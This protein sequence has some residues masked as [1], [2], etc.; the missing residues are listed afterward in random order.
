MYLYLKWKFVNKI[1]W[2]NEYSKNDTCYDVIK[3]CYND[4]I[5][6]DTHKKKVKFLV[7]YGSI[8]IKNNVRKIKMKKMRVKWPLKQCGK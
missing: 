8:T 6:T 1:K 3:N 7:F 5:H 2:R 4:K